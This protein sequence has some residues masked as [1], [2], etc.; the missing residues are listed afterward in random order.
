MQY[1]GEPSSSTF[2]SRTSALP[3]YVCQLAPVVP[4]LGTAIL[5]LM[6]QAMDLFVSMA[7]TLA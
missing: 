3:L 7:C 6:R 1:S 5:N 4:C 2:D